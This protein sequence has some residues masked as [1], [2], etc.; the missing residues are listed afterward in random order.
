MNVELDTMTPET[1]VQKGQTRIAQRFIA[2]IQSQ[3]I[4]TSEGRLNL[5]NVVKKLSYARGTFCFLQS[6]LRDAGP[7]RFEI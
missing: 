1:P 4:I 7:A 6:S 5:D 3:T 2:G